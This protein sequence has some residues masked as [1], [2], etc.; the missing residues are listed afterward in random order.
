VPSTTGP[1]PGQR[2][3]SC[4]TPQARAAR[5]LAGRRSRRPEIGRTGV[6]G[7]GAGRQLVV[8]GHSQAATRA[9]RRPRRLH[10]GDQGAG[11]SPRGPATF[12]RPSLM[13]SPTAHSSHSAS[14]AAPRRCCA[15]ATACSTRCH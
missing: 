10:R 9:L 5:D 3:S 1:R 2:S 4:R 13:Y 11:S 12:S 7:A 8:P 15:S 6:R 14:P